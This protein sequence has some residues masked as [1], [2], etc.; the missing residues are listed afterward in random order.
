M[1]AGRQEG[2]GRTKRAGF[3]PPRGVRGAPRC[4]RSR[5]M[6][7]VLRT[8]P[9]NV[10]GTSPWAAPG[11]MRRLVHASVVRESGPHNDTARRRAAAAS[12]RCAP[13]TQEDVARSGGRHRKHAR[14]QHRAKGNGQGGQEGSPRPQTIGCQPTQNGPRA[15]A[16]RSKSVEGCDSIAARCFEIFSAEIWWLGPQHLRSSLWPSQES[17]RPAPR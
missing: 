2:A 5:R 11:S 9:R 13:V 8:E 15:R 10:S 3:V 17:S 1:R 16:H 12:C 4:A 7:A 6:R 14:R